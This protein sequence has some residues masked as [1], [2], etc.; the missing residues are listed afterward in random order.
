[1]ISKTLDPQYCA[2][3]IE[4]QATA[5]IKRDGGWLTLR[6]CC[7]CGT[8]RYSGRQHWTEIIYILILSPEYDESATKTSTLQVQPQMQCRSDEYLHSGTS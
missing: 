5:I 8:E 6:G 3:V 2:P 7:V 4:N 1:M